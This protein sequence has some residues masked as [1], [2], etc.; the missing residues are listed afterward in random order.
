MSETGAK[1]TAAEQI[2]ERQ[3]RKKQAVIECFRDGM[4]MPEAAAKVGV[5]TRT[6]V[7][8][9]S[10]DPEFR[11]EIDEAR[12]RADDQVEAVMFRNA[13]NPDPAHNVIRIFWLKCRRPEVYR[14]T[15]QQRLVIEKPSFDDVKDALRKRAKSRKV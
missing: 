9:A 5:G 10:K 1:K 14:E 4:T 13:L 15:T 6:I 7:W 11:E 12:C 3:A 2:A 8:W